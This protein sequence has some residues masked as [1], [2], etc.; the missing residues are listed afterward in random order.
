M[1]EQNESG[2]NDNKKIIE[3]KTNESGGESAGAGAGGTN[4]TNINDDIE[5]RKAAN[6]L[7]IRLKKARTVAA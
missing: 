7:V 4:G 5:F 2:G 1:N 3:T 6:K